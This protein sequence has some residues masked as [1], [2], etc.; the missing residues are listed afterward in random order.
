MGA[1]TIDITFKRLANATIATADQGTLAIILKTED[2]EAHLYR[3]NKASEIPEGIDG[4]NRAY[5]ERGLMGNE[6]APKKLLL[7]TGSAVAD[8]L[9]ALAAE[10]FDWLAGP[11]EATKEEAE[12][13]VAHV[14]AAWEEDRYIRTVVAGAEA[15][16]HPG[17]VL[18]HEDSIVCGGKTYAATAYCSRIAGAICGTGKNGSITYMEL[19]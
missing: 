12:A 6:T 15:P 11:P 1:P 17:I 16:N 8:G 13:I 14:K 18:L 2:A 4:E 10:R 7:W 19:P 5:V 9:A 3:I